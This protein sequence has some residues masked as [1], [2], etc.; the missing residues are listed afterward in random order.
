[1]VYNNDAVVAGISEAGCAIYAVC[2]HSV[3]TFL[4]LTAI[5]QPGIFLYERSAGNPHPSLFG[6][7][8]QSE[9]RFSAPDAEKY[10]GSQNR[11]PNAILASTNATFATLFADQNCFDEA[12]SSYS[13]DFLC[14]QA[15]VVTSNSFDTSHYATPPAV[16]FSCTRLQGDL[17][18]P[19]SLITHLLIHQS[20]TPTIMVSRSLS[21]K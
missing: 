11:E 15:P 21:Q 19:F 7:I 10:T 17:I 16:S 3:L 5:V 8:V 1:M 13:S 12:T 6:D 9:D 4:L 20:P 2:V 18:R 14:Q